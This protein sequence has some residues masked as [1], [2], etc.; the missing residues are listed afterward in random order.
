MTKSSYATKFF[1][2]C[3][4]FYTLNFIHQMQNCVLIKYIKSS[5]HN[6]LIFKFITS[7]CFVSCLHS[8][9]KCSKDEYMSLR[10]IPMPVDIWTAKRGWFMNEEHIALYIELKVT[11]HFKGYCKL[12]RSYVGIVNVVIEHPYRRVCNRSII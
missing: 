12:G 6:V 11:K 10:S 8:D 9:E 4:S 3:K 2:C 7:T 5:A 1:F